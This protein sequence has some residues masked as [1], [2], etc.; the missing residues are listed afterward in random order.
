MYL[1]Q[2]NVMKEKINIRLKYVLLL[3]ILALYI[4]NSNTIY[5]CKYKLLV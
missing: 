3:R 1:F 4:R 5:V 2:F